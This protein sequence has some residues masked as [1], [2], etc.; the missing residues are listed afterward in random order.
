MQGRDPFFHVIEFWL[1]MTR[2]Y[3]DFLAGVQ[4][5]TMNDPESVRMMRAT[6][7]QVAADTPPDPRAV[8][9]PGRRGRCGKR[10]V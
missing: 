3:V 10:L 5:A 6:H 8:T 2:E 7:A 4:G 9:L 1:A